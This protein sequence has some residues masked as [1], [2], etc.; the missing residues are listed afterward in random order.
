MPRSA[1]V[2]RTTK[3]TDISV[4]WDLDHAGAAD[5]N[6]GIGFLDHMLEALGK[7]SGTTLKVR[8][9]GSNRVASSALMLLMVSWP[10]GSVKTATPW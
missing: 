5:I 8:C 4:T 6:T 9:K 2:N 7:H 10:V 3:E 1:T